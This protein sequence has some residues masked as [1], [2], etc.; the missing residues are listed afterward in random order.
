M[1]TIIAME[2]KHTTEISKLKNTKPYIFVGENN[3]SYILLNKKTGEM[4]KTKIDEEKSNVGFTIY[5]DLGLVYLGEIIEI[6]DV[7]IKF[8]LYIDKEKTK[9]DF[10]Y[11]GITYNWN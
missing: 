11:K 2:A 9:L 8:N 7:A 4:L 10:Q 6:N 1:R 5:R 3:T